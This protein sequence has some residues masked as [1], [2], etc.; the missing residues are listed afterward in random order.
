MSI[1]SNNIKIK[2]VCYIDNK[3]N[4]I[5]TIMIQRN[6]NIAGKVSLSTEDDGESIN[7]YY[8]N[9]VNGINEKCLYYFLKNNENKLMQLANMT[10]TIN[11]N[12]TN[13]E[14][15]EIPDISNDLQK[16]LLTQLEYYENICDNLLKINK[17]ILSKNIFNTIAHK[18]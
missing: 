3:P 5:G 14:N 16:D 6:S 2:D 9:N 10:K 1:E 7:I 17:T 18:I 12:K 8:L 15:F 4:N 13:I 11:L